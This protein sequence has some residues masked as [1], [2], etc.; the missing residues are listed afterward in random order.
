MGVQDSRV[1]LSRQVN[2]IL[3]VFGSNVKISGLNITINNNNTL[4]NNKIASFTISPGKCIV[5]TTLHLFPTATTLELDVSSYDP[6][7]YLVV[8]VSYSYTETL[9]QNRPIFKL[10][11]VTSDG[12]DQLPEEWSPNRDNLIL[13]VF[14]FNNHS[15]YNIELYHDNTISVNNNTY[16]INPTS[17]TIRYQH[18]L[19]SSDSEPDYN[20]CL[21]V[22]GDLYFDLV[23]KELFAYNG[24]SPIENTFE[25]NSN[26]TFE[27][28]NN[29][30]NG[31]ILYTLTVV[32]QGT[33]D[34]TVTSSPSGI[35]CGSTCSYH[36]ISG[37]SVTLTATPN[38]TSVFNSWS[39]DA[40]STNPTVIITMNSN[41]TVYATFNINEAG[42]FAGGINGNHQSYIDKLLFN[43]D[44]RSTLAVILSQS[45]YWQSACNSTSSGYFAGGLN[46]SVSYYSYIDKL[47]FSNE[48]RSTLETTLSQSIGVQ[49][50]CNSTLVGYFAG[51]MNYNNNNQSFID[52]LLFSNESRSTLTATLSRSVSIQSSCNSIL[53]GYFTGGMNYNNGYITQ[54]FIDKLLFNDESRITL[55]TT[56]S[57]SL[58]R[59]SACNSTLSGYFAGGFNGNFQSFID[60]LLFS[61]D[62]RIILATVLSQTIESQS[63]CNSTLAGYFAGGG[64][65]YISV[66]QSFIDKLLFSNESRI[67]LTTTLSQS[68]F[69]QSAC[70]SGG[71]V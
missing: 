50:A 13:G 37:Y 3:Q 34:G 44:S 16:T 58:W 10:L 38:S 66:F 67:T 24:W 26:Y 53:A 27:S 14:K 35:N 63:A 40:T 18:Y 36:F 46:S 43:N 33:G 4:I 20:R 45:V 61:N 9:Q 49:S 59:Q 42:Y 17:D 19:G 6:S 12:L 1:Y 51:G 68:V 11:Y 30:N 31:T 7:G 15:P 71:I 54:S 65:A 64:K 69:E 48:S 2:S 52:K 47:L 22:D 62:S 39:G 21:F 8:L 57:Q 55:T 23:Q 41:K 25:S 29:Y 28:S 56:L 5:D 60:K 32:K 70:Q